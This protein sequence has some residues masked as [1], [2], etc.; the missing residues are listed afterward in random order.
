[1]PRRA[2]ALLP[3]AVHDYDAAP[4]VWEVEDRLHL[5]REAVLCLN[6]STLVTVVWMPRAGP[7]SEKSATN[8]SLYDAVILLL[9]CGVNSV[10]VALLSFPS[11]V[12]FCLSHSHTQ[13]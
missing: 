4:L 2:V 7:D 9:L 10:V 11:S 8:I 12:C 13:I 1:M 3:V 6:Y 5:G